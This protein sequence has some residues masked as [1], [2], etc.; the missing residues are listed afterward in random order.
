MILSSSCGTEW[1][2]GGGRISG[3]ED[4]QSAYRS[5]LGGNTAGIDFLSHITLP[6][7][8]PQV[9]IVT[10]LDGKGALNMCGKEKEWMRVG[11]EHFDLIGINS[12][13]WS[14]SSFKIQKQHVLGH[15]DVLGRPLTLLE[16][17]NCTCD[18]KAKSIARREISRNA[19]PIFPED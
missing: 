5:E 3:S 19:R 15:Q 13:L 10:A 14:N 4:I 12:S 6:Q 18:I 16:I 9:P 7:Q 1:I 2:A 11:S 8:Q 17:L